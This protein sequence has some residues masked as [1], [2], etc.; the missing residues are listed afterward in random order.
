MLRG[1]VWWADLPDPAGRRPVVVLTRDSAIPVR[2]AVTVAPVTQ[3][4]RGI[5]VEV[6]LDSGDGMPV[7]CAIN[8]DN[9]LTVPQPLLDSR[10]TTLTAG[11]M[12]AV[13]EAIK[14]ALDLE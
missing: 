12:R 2:N 3:T 14:F 10:I 4:I 7:S 13:E 8:C 11:K 6:D 1:E 5:P 9:L